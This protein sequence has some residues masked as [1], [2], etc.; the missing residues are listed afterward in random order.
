MVVAIKSGFRPNFAES[1]PMGDD[2]IRA[3]NQFVSSV[4]FTQGGLESSYRHTGRQLQQFEQSKQTF[5]ELLVL[6]IEPLGYFHQ[7]VFWMGH[8]RCTRTG[9]Q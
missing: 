3:A 2:V 1:V 8:V 9:K 5:P 4:C 7:E 6:H